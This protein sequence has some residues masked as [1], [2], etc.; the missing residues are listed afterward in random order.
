MHTVT[1][2]SDTL[3]DPNYD[4]IVPKLF[5]LFIKCSKRFECRWRCFDAKQLL[6]KAGILLNNNVYVIM[7]VLHESELRYLRLK[8]ANEPNIKLLHV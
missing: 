6:M 8:K 7:K 5:I 1:L 3:T 2:M 4:F